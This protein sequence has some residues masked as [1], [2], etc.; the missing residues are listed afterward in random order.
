[1]G[2]VL[3][4]VG[5][6]GQ[7]V[8]LAALRLKILGALPAD[9]EAVVFD[10]DRKSDLTTRL[11]S[12]NGTL[13]D[14]SAH[15]LGLGEIVAP[16]DINKLADGH[17]SELFVDDNHKREAELFAGFFTAKE[18]E[19]NVRQGMYG[20]PTVGATAI[21]TG[22][23]SKEIRDTIEALTKAS[24][25]YLCGSVVG[26]TGAGITHKLALRLKEAGKPVHAIFLTRW[27]N[28]PAG[29]EV[30]PERLVRNQ[31]HGLQ[32]IV[33]HTLSEVI[34]AM[35]IG[36]PSNDPGGGVLR[37]GPA[38]AVETTSYLV[39]MAARALRELEAAQR[40]DAGTKAWGMA[41]DERNEE[42]LLDDQGWHEGKSLRFRFHVALA[43][44]NLLRH[45]A[46]NQAHIAKVCRPGPW[47][48]VMGG[49]ASSITTGLYTSINNWAPTDREAGRAF[50]AE[51]CT[52]WDELAKRLA[53]CREW[54]QKIY[55]SL[56][57]SAV[58][59]VFNRTLT[60]LSAQGKGA[61][62]KWK[63]LKAWLDPNVVARPTG[64]TALPSGLADHITKILQENISV[65]VAKG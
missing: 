54:L 62:G 53:F 49:D 42:W 2:D 30:S 28:V 56:Q 37:L 29:G 65:E 20:T 6:T 23:D 46:E 4:A 34:N 13:K 51:L 38:D 64:S 25:V 36:F 24:R 8:A 15:P 14:Q 48:R 58:G 35:I 40:L 7:H 63:L 1:M 55:P 19:T 61:E 47:D 26:G 31:R 33:D 45:L 50:V 39:L 44:E 41:H 43:M 22:I 59:S 32:Y 16:F 9:L 5:G 57:G 21:S 12:V 27:F 17:F 60:G 18:A 52:R 10:P 3:V 11:L